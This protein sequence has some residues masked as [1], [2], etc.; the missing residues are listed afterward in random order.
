M[1]PIMPPKAAA[2]LALRRSPA[3]ASMPACV[4]VPRIL[5]EAVLGAASADGCRP[6]L[7]LLQ[8]S[9]SA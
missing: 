4:A 2:A 6:S 7:R 9:P 8:G 1:A 3:T 5:K